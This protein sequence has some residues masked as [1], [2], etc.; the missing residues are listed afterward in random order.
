MEREG[1]LL[2]G[3]G[4]SMDRLIAVRR[5]VAEM[6]SKRKKCNSVQFPAQMHWKW[7]ERVPAPFIPSPSVLRCHVCHHM[8][9]SQNAR[10]KSEWV[11]LKGDSI[12]A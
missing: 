11:P 10:T 9:G 8:G 2:R 7:L 4:V 12:C 5:M 3:P 1:A 6:G